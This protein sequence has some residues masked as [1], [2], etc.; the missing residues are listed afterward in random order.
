MRGRWAPPP[1]EGE[2]SREAQGVTW[3]DANR[4]RELQTATQPGVMPNAPLTRTTPV[5]EQDEVLLPPFPEPGNLAVPFPGG[6]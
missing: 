6:L 5:S 1:T 4:R 3:R 2:G